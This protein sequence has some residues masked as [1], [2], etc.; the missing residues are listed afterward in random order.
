LDYIPDERIYRAV[1]S[2]Q[3]RIERGAPHNVALRQASARYRI[4]ERV[5]EDTLCRLASGRPVEDAD[6]RPPTIRRVF[7]DPRRE[8][9]ARKREREQ[10]QDQP[11]PDWARVIRDYA[12]LGLVVLP[13][14]GKAPMVRYKHITAPPSDEQVRLWIAQG[15]E[16]DAY[17]LRCGQCSGVIVFDFDITP[18]GEDFVPVS[19]PEKILIVKDLSIYAEL[20]QRCEQIVVD[21]RRGIH[22]YMRCHDVVRTRT[23]GEYYIGERDGQYVEVKDAEDALYKVEVHLR[24]EGAGVI[25]PPSPDKRWLCGD[26][27]DLVRTQPPQGIID[28]LKR[29]DASQQVLP[30]KDAGQR[31]KEQRLPQQ[32]RP[33][34]E[35]RVKL[36]KGHSGLACIKGIITAILNGRDCYLQHERDL[37]LFT[38]YNLIM[39]TKRNTKEYAQDYIR[40]LN[41]KFTVP[42]SQKELDKVFSKVY[43][44]FGCDAVR[45]GVPWAIDFCFQCPITI[46]KMRRQAMQ[47][48]LLSKEILADLPPSAFKLLYLID[49]FGK[50]SI[51]RLAELSG[52][53]R[54]SVIQGLKTL[55]NFGLLPDTPLKSS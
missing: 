14:R 47:Y 21:T 29:Y 32:E 18:E 28:A 33:S 51:N 39:R 43:Y 22:W 3:A 2:Y 25:I 13:A 17:W 20:Y 54:P 19:T 44:D 45:R 26:M 41:S 38:L 11:E 4:S 37:V 1:L 36:P 40:W 34:R 9:R 35:R 8:T 53:S 7:G 16:P 55:R 52:L 23:L 49:L 12:R 24:G 27:E 15:I 5:L 46:S 42:L 30:L 6:E 31:G 50:L 10:E 48:K